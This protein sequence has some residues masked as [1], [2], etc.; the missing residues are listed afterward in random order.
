MGFHPDD[1]TLEAAEF[2]NQHNE[3][4][5][6]ILNTSLQQGDM[7]VW[8]AGPKRRTYV[9]GRTRLF[10]HARLEEW[11]AIRNALKDDDVAKWKPLLDRYEISAVMIEPAVV[12]GAP[13]TYRKLMRSP[14]W[15]PFYDDGRIV[16]F[17]RADAT[18]TDLTFFNAN[19]LDPELRAYRVTHPVANF[20]RPPSATTWIDGVFQNR[21]FSRPQSRTESCG[22]LARGDRAGKYGDA[23]ACPHP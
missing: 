6:N 23:P 15:V 12:G 22:A 21:T 10:P 11:H 13:N 8:K 7:L 4:K 17:G 1:F 9:D 16:M 14:N 2:L 19:K 18:G 20:E 5:G 3:I